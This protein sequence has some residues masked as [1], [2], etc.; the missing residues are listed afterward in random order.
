MGTMNLKVL[1]LLSIGAALVV[2]ALPMAALAD[3]QLDD[4]RQFIRTASQDAGRH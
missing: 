1:L 3:D 2:K 4:I